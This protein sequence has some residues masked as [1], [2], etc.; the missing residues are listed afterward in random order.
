VSNIWGQIRKRGTQP[1][2][3]VE[4]SSELIRSVYQ[5]LVTGG[6]WHENMR[7]RLTL[8]LTAP[9]ALSASAFSP[10]TC[11]TSVPSPPSLVLSQR[12]QTR[13]RDGLVRL[14]AEPEGADMDIPRPDPSILVSAMEPSQQK[15]AVG[16]ISAGILLGTSIIVTFLGLVEEVLPYGWFDLWRD[17][18]WPVPLGLIFVAAGVSHF[19]LKDSFTSIVPPR[20]IWGGLWDVPAPGAEELGLTYEEY[21]SYWTGVAE[22]GGG[23]LLAGSGI[24]LFDIPVQVPA[25][26]LCLL[27]AAVTPANIYMFTHDAQMKNAPAI[28]YPYGHLGRGV[29]QCVLLAFFWKLTFRS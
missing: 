22:I 28:P 12:R 23:L 6:W 3:K 11:I 16:A 2:V 14:Y 17:Y 9:A 21:H 29:A 19:A 15:L 20:G 7:T 5:S 1:S 25:F 24:G 13:H 10:P 26:L 4:R 8:I 18:T 27:V